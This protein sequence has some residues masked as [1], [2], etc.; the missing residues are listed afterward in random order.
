MCGDRACR[1]N[2]DYF[3][4][5]NRVYE[6]RGRQKSGLQ[7]LEFRKQSYMHRG[8][9]NQFVN[10]SYRSVAFLSKEEK[11]SSKYAHKNCKRNFCVRSP[12]SLALAFALSLS[13][14][15]KFTMLLD[16][17]VHKNYL[18][19]AFRKEKQLKAK[20]NKKLKTAKTQRQIAIN[21][22]KDAKKSR[23]DAVKDREDAVKDSDTAV[24]TSTK[25]VEDLDKATQQHESSLRALGAEKDKAVAA[26]NGETKKAVDSLNELK[27]EN[28]QLVEQCRGVVAQGEKDKEAKKAADDENKRLKAELEEL[29]KNYDAAK[30]KLGAMAELKRNVDKLSKTV[31]AIEKEVGKVANLVSSDGGSSPSSPS[32]PS[33]FSSLNSN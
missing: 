1:P 30:N 32:S 21:E 20:A 2:H 13:R 31:A 15:L 16:F 4:V 17:S 19:R 10:Q 18:K 27:E 6:N 9:H 29:K 12:R 24:A 7:H 22:L 26:A 14:S 28:Q 8:Q 5:E 25:A 23:E 3:S 11:L 33:S